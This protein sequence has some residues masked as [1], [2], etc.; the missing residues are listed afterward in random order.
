MPHRQFCLTEVGRLDRGD[1]EVA[2]RD[3]ISFN[4]LLRCRDREHL[5]VGL[6]IPSFDFAVL[7]A[8]EQDTLLCRM[9]VQ[10]SDLFGRVK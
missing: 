5:L 7:A 3:P 10:I 6:L 9:P 4:G 2:A 8:G 1:L